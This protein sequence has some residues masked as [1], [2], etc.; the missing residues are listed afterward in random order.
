MKNRETRGAYPESGKVV[1]I[2]T[3]FRMRLNA[4]IIGLDS[5]K[6]NG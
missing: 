4:E 3:K 2:S 6:V 5:R 1:A